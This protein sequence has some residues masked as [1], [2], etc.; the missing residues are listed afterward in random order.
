MQIAK[1][2]PAAATLMRANFVWSERPD[3]R[4]AGLLALT[5]WEPHSRGPWLASTAR[6][7]RT[8]A[9]IEEARTLTY[10]DLWGR[11]NAFAREL[12]ARDAG[13]GRRVGILA[14]NHGGFVEWTLAASKTGTDVV[15][16]NTGLA[17]DQLRD[18]MSGEAI[19][20]VLPDDEFAGDVACP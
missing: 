14:R 15:F 16:L 8:A 3:R 11:T 13:P 18:V 4:T 17:A 6:A 20:L 5:R 10:K 9:V 1:P 7:G 12:L 2:V 19:D